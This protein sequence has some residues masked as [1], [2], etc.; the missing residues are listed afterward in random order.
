MKLEEFHVPALVVRS[1]STVCFMLLGVETPPA[2][3]FY[4]IVLRLNIVK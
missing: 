3:S 2:I 1:R 4:A